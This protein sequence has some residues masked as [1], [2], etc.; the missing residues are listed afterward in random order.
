M[1]RTM[2]YSQAFICTFYEKLFKYCFTFDRISNKNRK[3]TILS[4]LVVL[5]FNSKIRAGI[6]KTLKFLKILNLQKS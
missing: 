5:E 3:L 1:E 6:W 2:E 4:I